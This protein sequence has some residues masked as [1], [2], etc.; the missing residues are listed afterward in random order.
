VNIKEKLTKD[1]TKEV[2]MDTL[3]SM[4]AGHIGLNSTNKVGAH[5]TF[6]L[7]C[8]LKG[9]NAWILCKN[10]DFHIPACT[11]V[12]PMA[13]KTKQRANTAANFMAM[14][15]KALTSTNTRKSKRNSLRSAK[16]PSLVRAQQKNGPKCPKMVYNL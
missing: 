11:E 9:L 4:V 14:E 15:S 12:A 8:R 2:V 3:F 5:T 13:R 16:F 1:T 6:Y 7:T 10:E